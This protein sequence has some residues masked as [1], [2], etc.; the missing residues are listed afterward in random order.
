MFERAFPHRNAVDQGA[1]GAVEIAQD[2]AAALQLNR[3]VAA[4][5]HAIGNAQPDRRIAAEDRLDAIDWE[6]LATEWAGQHDQ[7]RSS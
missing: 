1:V 3:A 4:G 5:H 7:S 6:S 2:E